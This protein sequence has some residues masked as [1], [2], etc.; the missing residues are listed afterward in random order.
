[1]V[2]LSTKFMGLSLKNPV[3]PSA[4][5][6][7]REINTITAMEDAGAG[8]VVLYSLFEE[9]IT[10]ETAELEHYL[11]YGSNR[12]A[13]SLTYF[14][15]VPEYKTGPEEYL[16]HIRKAKAAVQIPIIASL[17]GSTIG[18]WMDFARQIEQAGADGLE[19]NVYYI[20]AD[21]QRNGVEIE[22]L[23][24][25]VLKTVKSVVGIPVAMKLSPFFSA[26]AAMCQQLDRFGADGLVL[27]N[28]F[29]QPD[30]DLGKLEV[31]PHHTLST[32]TELRLPLRWVA[33]LFGRIH[34]SMA[35][36]S[37]VHEP[38]DVIKAIMAGADVVQT[39]SALLSGGVRKITELVDGTA[40]WMDAHEYASVADMRGSMSARAIGDPAAFER[41]NYVKTLHTWSTVQ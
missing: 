30:F 40:A 5:P 15:E 31:V 38:A 32:S 6:L 11:E 24:L 2:D 22:N 37:G 28:R 41:A 9:Q 29:F 1:M 18:G 23:Y 14:P 33:L 35:L 8:A 19:L 20:A 17:N 12:F 3:V 16:E 36:T 26:T 7:S 10:H 39:C 25:D 21:P 13:E 27:F 4:S 34:A